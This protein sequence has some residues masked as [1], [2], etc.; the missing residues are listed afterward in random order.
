M[1]RFLLYATGIGSNLCASFYTLPIRPCCYGIPHMKLLNIQWVACTDGSGV[2]ATQA[3]K[4]RG[5][6]VWGYFVSG[7][8]DT[9]AYLWNLAGT[10]NSTDVCVCR[11][12]RETASP[13]GYERHLSQFR[14]SM[15][16]LFGSSMSG[17]SSVGGG[18]AWKPCRCVTTPE[19]SVGAMLLLSHRCHRRRALETSRALVL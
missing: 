8:N 19:G 17:A 1:E 3:R 5:L 7:C 4:L 6:L 16:P 14:K 10:A 11:H 2:S 9:W 12:G 15:P 13:V 18:A